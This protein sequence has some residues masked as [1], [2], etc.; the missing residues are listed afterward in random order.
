MSEAKGIDISLNT[1]HSGKIG[2]NQLR[3]SAYIF[4]LCL[5]VCSRIVG[6]STLTH[7]LFVEK[8]LWSALLP[9]IT[10]V[11]CLAIFLSYR[12]QSKKKLMIMMVLS[13]FVL[14]ITE[15]SNNMAFSQIFFFVIA[16]PIT[17]DARKIAKW[18]SYCFIAVTAFVF[19]M[20]KA[21]L[22]SGNE[23]FREEIVRNSCGFSSA[24]G[25]ANTI[26]LSLIAFVYY[27]QDRWKLK[28]S[29]IW[30]CVIAYVFALTNSRMSCALGLFVVVVM[31]FWYFK[32]KQ[33]KKF[34]YTFSECSFIVGLGL[35]VLA[36][37]LYVNGYFMVALTALN[38]FL[39]Y[40]LSYM[41]QY[42]LDPGI[43]LF[44]QVLVMVSK[45]QMLSTGERWSGLDNSYMYMLIVWGIV[46]IA[47]FT[48]FMVFLG[49]YLK[50][51]ENYYGALCVLV[52]SIVGIKENY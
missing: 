8:S 48:L 34:I 44:G 40:R 43:S 10:I 50:R 28:H 46:G 26:L 9:K 42:F 33:I 52:L 2:V 15:M 31:T 21:G 1:Q 6:S 20:Y 5:N 16:Y 47:I 24:N 3:I 37:V 14:I 27:K 4:L 30:S 41:S 19:L 11:G 38:S 32:G 36:T 39:T 29:I 51:T 45:A 23:D 17:L 35:S 49:K 13:I 12:R 7:F 18:E 25:F 22:I